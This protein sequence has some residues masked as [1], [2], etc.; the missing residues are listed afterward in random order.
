MK[1]SDLVKKVEKLG[2]DT[3]D[4]KAQKTWS[5]SALF[6]VAINFIPVLFGGGVIR[7]RWVSVIRPS[8]RRLYLG[9]RET[10]HR[11]ISVCNRSLWREF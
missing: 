6:A 2:G 7:T 5:S 10:T 11:C 4:K 3:D 1:V 9:L 8:Y